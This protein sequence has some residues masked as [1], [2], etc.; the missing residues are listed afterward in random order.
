MSTPSVTAFAETATLFAVLNEDW[1]EVHRIVNDMLPGERATFAE[2]LNKLAGLL[3]ARCERC[4]ALTP[5]GTSVTIR[6]LGPEREYLCKSCADK[7][8]ATV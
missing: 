8:R 4:D 5:I 3:G 1:Q 2:Q 7:A 6:P